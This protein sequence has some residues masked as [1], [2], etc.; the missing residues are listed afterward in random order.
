MTQNAGRA[1]QPL[2]QPLFILSI[3]T[4]RRLLTCAR[5]PKECHKRF[6]T[7]Q[8]RFR[9]G[10]VFNGRLFHGKALHRSNFPRVSFRS[11]TAMLHFD[12]KRR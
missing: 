4:L 10:L 1:S 9:P 5:A 6:F 7:C 2:P 12:V 8:T 3:M 11:G